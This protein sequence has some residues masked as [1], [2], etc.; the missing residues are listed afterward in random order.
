MNLNRF[1]KPV[2]ECLNAAE[3]Y[4]VVNACQCP[5]CYQIIFSRNVFDEM[6]CSCGA[7]SIDGKKAWYNL[8]QDVTAHRKLYSEFSDNGEPS[9]FK[10]T[11]P[12]TDHLLMV[13]KNRG[14][15]RLG[16]VNLDFPFVYGSR[17][18]K[19]S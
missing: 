11:V 7:T 6:K 13:D 1:R 4:S 17:K 2:S 10:L 9:I 5:R 3:R 8:G 16:K 12:Y 15:D 14:F 18:L 19:V